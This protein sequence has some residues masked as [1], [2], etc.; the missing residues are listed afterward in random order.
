MMRDVPNESTAPAR[1][2]RRTVALLSVAQ[3]FSGVGTGAVVSVGSLIAYQL[4]GRE[5][6]SGSVTTLMTLGAALAAVPLAQLASRRGRRVALSSGLAIAL[7]GAL[8][9][10]LATVLGSFALLLVCALLL[11]AGNT[12]NLQARFAAT[13]LSRAEHR[14]RDLSIV[15]WM[16]SFGAIAGP[17]LIS[18]S[19]TLASTLGLPA[20]AGIFLIAAAGMLVGMLAIW[21][22]LRPDPLLT[23][24]ELTG[25][26]GAPR[27]KRNFQAGLAAIRRAPVALTGLVGV[28]VA[29]AVMV[30]IMSMTSVHLSG[31][32][33]S[34]TIIGVTIS[35]HIAGMYLFSPIMGTLTDRIGGRP[36]VLTGMVVI[37]VSAVLAALAGTNHA[38][39]T[40]ALF[41]L[42]LG[43]SAA[44]VAGAAMISGAV[45]DEVRVSV[46]GSTDML[47]SVAGGLGGLL[48][49]LVLGGIGY[50]G[51]SWV[52]A[53]LAVA[54]RAF[55]ARP[56]G[57]GSN[58]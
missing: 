12:V 32:G 40:V 43:W 35:L 17:N 38:L 39:I 56:G 31:H 24:R 58:R 52:G 36:T 49:G 18:P 8:G 47:M 7:V 3:I 45:P 53:A 42:G 34:L 51:L 13:D 54:A 19:S 55:L 48:A 44:S 15:V 21:I 11:G 4:S 30:A 27:A 10:I 16:S 37:L 29:H 5:S 41:L 14:G 20:L 1:L 23:A 26:T 28:T 22:G 33:A 6:L 46:Q 2:Q 57:A 9:V 25:E 50:A